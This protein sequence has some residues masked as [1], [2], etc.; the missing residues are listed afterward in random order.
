[1]PDLP[2]F[3]VFLFSLEKKRRIRRRDKKTVVFKT[4]PFRFRFPCFQENKAIQL[5]ESRNESYSPFDD[6]RM[7]PFW[8]DTFFGVHPKGSSDSSLKGMHC[9][10]ISKTACFEGYFTRNLRIRERLAILPVG[11]H[12][13]TYLGRLGKSR[14]TSV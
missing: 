2:S 4:S 13:R 10:P 14:Q 9:A 12:E 3:I 5:L 6:V 7:L 1:M 8:T 11:I